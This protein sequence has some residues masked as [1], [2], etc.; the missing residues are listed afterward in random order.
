MILI[1]KYSGVL[2]VADKYCQSCKRMVGTRGGSAAGV[3]TAIIGVLIFLMI[4][5]LGLL[6]GLPMVLVGI[7]MLVFSSS[8]CSICGTT[9]LLISAPEEDVPE[10]IE[11]KPLTVETP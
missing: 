11:A 6:I 9:N 8:R 1:I 10:K 2:C 7:L 3:I 4:P 5:F